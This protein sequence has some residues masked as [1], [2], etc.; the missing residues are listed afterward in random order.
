MF[1]VN[2][3]SRRECMFSM[4][5][6]TLA[7]TTDY[8]PKIETQ[9]GEVVIN[10]THDT[11]YLIEP[12]PKTVS[13]P[14]GRLASDMLATISTFVDSLKEHHR[15]KVQAL[16][17]FIHHTVFYEY[18]SIAAL[19]TERLPLFRGLKTLTLVMGKQNDNGN[20]P[21]SGRE[22]V[23]SK[24]KGYDPRRK[25]AS[26]L[27]QCFM[28]SFRDTQKDHPSWKKPAIVN[29]CLKQSRDWE[30]QRFMPEFTW[31]KIP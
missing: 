5:Y 22:I 20:T 21:Y 7:L 29:R 8:I 26:S 24:I 27:R 25:H 3:E 28:K 12:D 11:L 1:D 2:R 9:F 4:G 13:P 10:F 30:Q 31:K 23:F 18:S 15:E 19:I 16:A 14:F 17:I 6:E